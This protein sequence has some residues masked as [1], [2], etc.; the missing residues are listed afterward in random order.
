MRSCLKK[1]FPKKNGLW[2]GSRCSLNSNLSTCPTKKKR[3][4]KR[5]E[6]SWARKYTLV[7]PALW[8]LRQEDLEFKTS[9]SYNRDLEKK[10]QTNNAP[11]KKIN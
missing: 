6:N 8:N 7:T 9:L 4:K 11:P 3:K 1:P 2:S 5:K 10:N